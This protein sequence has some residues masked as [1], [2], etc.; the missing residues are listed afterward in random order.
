MSNRK[1]THINRIKLPI[2]LILCCLIAAAVPVCG[3]ERSG[4]VKEDIKGEIK[5]DVPK[6]DASLPGGMSGLG[7]IYQPRVI[8][9]ASAYKL[10][11]DARL[12]QEVA[13]RGGHR[14]MLVGYGFSNG[15]RFGAIQLLLVSGETKVAQRLKL[16][17]GEAPQ[18]EAMS[19]QNGR[20][21]VFFRVI[22]EAQTVNALVYS[23]V[24][25]DA[26]KLAES[27]RVDQNFPG[28]MKL[29]VKGTLESG[30]IVSVVSANPQ[31]T[32]RLDL[33]NP[34]AADELIAAGLYDANGEPV[35]A[36]KNLSLARTG[37]ESVDAAQGN[38]I[39]VGMS[40]VSLSK[41]RVVDVTAALTQKGG[42]KWV[43]TAINFEPFLPFRSE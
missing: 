11:K 3:R 31:K 15:G 25:A 22:R 27:L 33:S 34:E 18:I 6:E 26:P 7:K 43:V 8:E 42:D 24:G 29:N 36:L 16:G 9:N 21:A 1:G 37:S 10:P 14:L 39:R 19:L 41:K 2:A 5:I 40:L 13:W 12:I 20:R 23:D 17:A 28:R 38:T 4:D 32:E 30:G 35:P